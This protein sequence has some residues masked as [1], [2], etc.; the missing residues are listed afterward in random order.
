MSVVIYTQHTII[1][2]P[3][4]EVI[5]YLHTGLW[6]VKVSPTDHIFVNKEQD[7]DWCTP[8]IDVE[9]DGLAMQRCQMICE[10][11]TIVVYE[12]ETPGLV[13]INTQ[14]DGK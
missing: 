6:L 9:S 1:D 12:D 14:H 2:N 8:V 13:V 7:R 10:A 5:G 4:L 11:I 3:I